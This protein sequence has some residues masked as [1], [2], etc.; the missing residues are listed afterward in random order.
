[1]ERK[2]LEIISFLILCTGIFLLAFFV[3]K[4]FFTILALST[5]LVFL[6]RPL[7][8]K[9]IHFYGGGNT[10]F[11]FLIVLVS[12]L[13]LILPLI[14]FGIKILAQVQS[15][16]TL[17][18]A[19]QIPDIQN[20]QLNIEIFMRHIFPAF[21]FDISSYAGTILG[22]VSN[23]FGELISQTS[24]M[25]FQ[26]FFLLVTF[27]FFLRDGETIFPEIISLSPFSKIQTKEIVNSVHR[28]VT[29]VIRGTLFVGIIRWVIF[30]VGFYFLG[31]PNP[32]VFGS[33]AGII[34]I[35]PGLGTPFVIIPTV[36]Y[37][38]VFNNIFA[39]IGTI[40]F[41][42]LVL[43]F[44]DN[45]LSAYFFGKGLEASPIFILFSIL[46]GVL[47][48]GPLGFIFGPIILSLCISITEMYKILILKPKAQMKS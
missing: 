6:F 28:A 4:P 5:V 14:F 41:G 45:M 21:S 44:V 36:A 1:M 46:G 22:F 23:N 31:I 24:Y 43:F 34:G 7:H 47:F 13:F 29:S 18:Q 12:L 9:L 39:A 37:F 8:K 3:F 42:A 19:G 15:F 32:M 35:I 48:F 25:F 16:F 27:F 2:K 11:A 26:I 33:I 10:F 40:F 30:M 38:F 20:L 17:V